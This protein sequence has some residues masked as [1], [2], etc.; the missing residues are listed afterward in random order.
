MILF[1]RARGW[2]YG[3]TRE[4]ESLQA[5]SAVA[6]R[7]TQHE[8][9]RQ[10][11]VMLQLASVKSQLDCLTEQLAA[12]RHARLPPAPA[13]ASAAQQL[14]AQQLAASSALFIL[15]DN[16]LGSKLGYVFTSGAQG[17]GYYRDGTCDP[18][19]SVAHCAAAATGDAAVVLV[20]AADGIADAP[21]WPQ[22][23]TRAEPDLVD[24]GVSDG[25]LFVPSIAYHGSRPGY[26]YFRSSKFGTGYYRDGTS[27]G[28]CSSAESPAAVAAG[29]SVAADVRAPPRLPPGLPQSQLSSFPSALRLAAAVPP[30]PPTRL[31]PHPSHR[32]DTS[33][34]RRNRRPCHDAV[35]SQLSGSQPSPRHTASYL[36]RGRRRRQRAALLE[37]SGSSL[38]QH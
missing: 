21:V 14:A 30:L 5:M 38:F 2:A 3:I 19:V 32:R 23:Q 7:E 24:E 35:P 8:R 27:P 4:F 26:V 36:R 29:P 18:A 37:L 17:T 25:D 15:A 20:A 10:H 31:Q 1:A 9:T 22:R 12:Q 13:A 6:E 11:D 34:L 33:Y 28:S 16:F